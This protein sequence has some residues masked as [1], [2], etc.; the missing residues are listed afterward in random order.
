MQD[1][2]D[3]LNTRSAQEA[4]AKNNV[5]DKDRLEP[6]MWW[7]AN[8]PNLRR[9]DDILK[10][11]ENFNTR[12]ENESAEIT[13][14]LSILNSSF[15]GEGKELAFAST[16]Y[17]S[18]QI[19]GLE[20]DRPPSTLSSGEAQLFVI[21]THLLFNPAAQQANVFL[22]DEPELSL[23]VQWQ[24]LFVDSICAANPNVQYI[25]ATHSPSIILDRFDKCK[26]VRPELGRD[27]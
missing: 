23:H 6:L 7:S 2:L 22:I 21:L 17:L 4:F 5:V 18:V 15:K 13:R 26:D 25:L 10:T 11:V 19:A 3:K 12:Q 9:L 20:G 27:A 14:Y 16:G 24:E 1:V 8:H